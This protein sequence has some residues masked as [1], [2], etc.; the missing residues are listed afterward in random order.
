MSCRGYA[1]LVLAT[2]LAG[3]IATPSLAQSA[4]DGF[5]FHVPHGS[6]GLR[7]G[8]DHAMAGSD[9]FDF[10]TKELTLRRSDFSSA[11]LGTSVAIRVTPRND[12]V[13][14]LGYASVSRGSEFRDWI[15][16]NN[17]P[18]TQTTSLRRIPVTF[19]VR[20]YLGQRGRAIG[21]FAWIPAAQ[22]PY[23]GLGAGVMQYRFRQVGDWVNPQTL[24]INFDTFESKAWT[25]V[26]HALAGM[27]FA[28][29]RFF[30][31][32]GEVRYTWA[33][34]PMR[35]DFQNFNKIDLSGL[36]ATA[37]FSVRL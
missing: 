13:F 3:G 17:Q 35:S 21:R 15:D 16:N 8:F 32:N 1:A 6:W 26:V 14:D 33:H 5:L 7:V 27:D 18:I 36:S 29:G 31:L 22:T 12:V 4:G 24:A 11:T 19:G 37:G 2:S 20:H 9:V 10:V 25:P 30:L 23:I 34:G 28:L